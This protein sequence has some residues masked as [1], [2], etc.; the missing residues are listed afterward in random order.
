M[1][2]D[3][4]LTDTQQQT[5]KVETDAI[6]QELEELRAALAL[7][8]PQLSVTKEYS[9]RAER[10]ESKLKQLTEEMAATVPLDIHNRVV[11]LPSLT[12]S[13][14]RNILCCLHPECAEGS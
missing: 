3:E 5:S 12:L 10:A 9:A 2:S 4:R 7:L 6:A 1:R 8:E 14:K 11:R 13:L